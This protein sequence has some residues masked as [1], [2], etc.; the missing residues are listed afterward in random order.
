MKINFNYKFRKLDGKPMLERAENEEDGG[1]KTKKKNP[2]FTL[3]TVCTTVLLS[4][5]LDQTIC[6]QCKYQIKTLEKLSG[7]EKVKR[8]LLATK[9][10]DSTDPV[11]VGTKD[12]ELLKDLIAKNYLP[13]IV[14]Q[15]WCVLDPSE[16]EENKKKK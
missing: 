16:T 10:Y 15:A 4:P 7:E 8:F 1:K 3:K 2:V 6:P 11:N 12:I 9:I 5:E 13:L 14:G